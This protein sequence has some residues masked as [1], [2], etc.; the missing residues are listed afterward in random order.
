MDPLDKAE[1]KLS[2]VAIQIKGKVAWVTC[3]QQLIYISRMPVGMNISVSTNILEKKDGKWLMVVHHASPLPFTH[4]EF[5]IEK[6]D[7]DKVQ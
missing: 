5:E 2:N 4:H 7:E 6:I 3:I 1:S